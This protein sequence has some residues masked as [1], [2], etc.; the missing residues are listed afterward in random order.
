VPYINAQTGQ[1]L[2]AN[3]GRCNRQDKCGYH[4]KPRQYFADNP[5]KSK[6][7][8]RWQPGR[9]AY[10]FSQP[11]TYTR[12]APPRVKTTAVAPAC[13]YI[14]DNKVAASLKM[15][16]QNNFVNFLTRKLG[17]Q[18][19]AKLVTAYRIGTSK[20]WPGATL[21]W[22]LDSSGRAR[23]GKIMLYHTETGKRVKEP[24]NHIA[25]VHALLMRNAK[26]RIRN[27]GDGKTSAIGTSHSAFVL[28]Q[29]LFGEHLLAQYPHKTVAVVES[30]KTA[31]IAAHQAPQYVWVATGCA[32]N[33]NAA[34]CQALA[35]RKVILYPDLGAYHR[36]KAI[37]AGLQPMLKGSRFTVSGLLERSATDEDRERGLD[38][39]DYL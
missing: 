23:T 28:K 38:L 32:G 17:A 21:F 22:Q 27:E 5:A 13:S 34:I 16:N 20:H 7:A 6:P 18:P 29:C 8:G 36:W 30:E 3:V 33:L 24:F 26:W 2:A 4:Y 31:I 9:G 1:Q 11:K 10:P 35:H 19:A 39:G 14:D 37:A 25:W 12:P 15:Y